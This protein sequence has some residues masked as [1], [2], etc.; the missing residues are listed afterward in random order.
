LK[1]L[2]V[3]ILGA[4]QYDRE[5]DKYLG[6]GASY[7]NIPRPVLYRYNAYDVDCTWEL[8]EFFDGELERL[9]LRKLHD[10]LVAASNELMF[11][12]LNGIKFDLMH[13]AKLTT[14]YLEVLGKMEEALDE[15]V[16]KDYDK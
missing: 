1:Y 10:F 6:K 12:E 5:L 8:A 2:A 11:L 15:M 7:A 14:S 4:P 3:E 9:G 16:P 13:N